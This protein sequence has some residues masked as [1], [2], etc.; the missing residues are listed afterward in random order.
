MT[1]DR[2][3]FIQASWHQDIV[4][5]G[6]ESFISELEKSGF[7]KNNI[8]IYNVPGSLEIPLQAQLLAKSGMSGSETD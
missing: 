5:Q 8:D 2:I 6:R 1:T 3:A 7:S 4:S